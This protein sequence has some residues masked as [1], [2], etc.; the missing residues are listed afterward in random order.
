MQIH[1]DGT[2][3]LSDLGFAEYFGSA[4]AALPDLDWDG[5]SELAIGAS[6]RPAVGMDRYI[7]AV[8]VLFLDASGGVKSG[9]VA[10]LTDGYQ[11]LALAPFSFFGYSIAS[12]SA[13]HLLLRCDGL[14]RR[15][16]GVR[17]AFRRAAVVRRGAERAARA[18]AP[19]DGECQDV[20]AEA[21]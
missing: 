14:R 8:Y 4:A 15:A 10:R 19:H 13:L 16:R 21:G 20:R 18:A 11:G 9:G 7:G 1:K 17:R 12:L 5:V 6:R 2:S 3:E